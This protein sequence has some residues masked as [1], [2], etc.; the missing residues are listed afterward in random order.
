LFKRALAA[1]QQQDLVK[2]AIALQRVLEVDS[3]NALAWH[4]AGTIDLQR[5]NYEPASLKLARAVELDPARAEFHRTLAR[6][7]YAAGALADA[8]V[9]ARRAIDLDASS[10]DAWIVLG[11][12]LE[13]TEPDAALAAWEKAAALVPS[14]PEAQFRIGNMQRRRGNYVAA[15]SAYRAARAAGLNHPVLLNNLAL[16]LQEQEQFDEAEQCYQRA[17]EQQPTLLEANA[18]LGDLLYRR[19]R[20]AEALSSYGRAIALKPENSA[21]WLNLGLCQYRVAM[22]PAAEASLKRAIELDPHQPNNFVGM[23]A[24]LLAQQR[25]AEALPFIQRALELQPDLPDARSMQLYANQQTCNWEGLGLLF[26]QQRTGI[27][28]PDAPAVVPHNL[29]GL[30]YEPA[31]LLT[32]AR[33]W[34]AQRIRPKPIRRPPWPGLVEGRLRI[35]YLGSDFR[36]H[37]LANLLTEVI[38]RH[39]RSRFEVYGY[40]FGPDDKSAAR[41]RFIAAFDT[42]VDVR[43]ETFEQTAR[44]VRDDRI[45][46]LFDTGGYVLN[47]RSEIFALRPAPLQ[48]NCI[49]FPATLGADYY[50]YIL[51]DTFVTPPAQ[52]ENYAE[53]FMLLP[54][55]Y[56]PGDTRRPI[57]ETPTRAQCQLPATG[58]VF[59][60]FNACWKIHPML[61]DVWM[62]LLRKTPA[63]VLWLLDTNAASRDNLRRE[64]HQRGIA[65]ERLIFAPSLPLAEHLARHTVADLFLD[66]FP[67]NAHTTSNDAL[68]T[69]LPVLTCAGETFASRVSGSQLHA[70]GL[71]ELVTYS[72]ADYEALAL[73]LAN[74]PALLEGYRAR[75]RANR[76]RE[77][78]FDTVRYTRALEGLISAAA[79]ELRPAS[80]D[81]ER[82]PLA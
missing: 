31:E 71:P 68:F 64:A 25:E 23:A 65:P 66:T 75:L 48:I 13:A 6:A 51:A 61:F 20:F 58:F 30:P 69:G 1:Y 78:L 27:H 46:V 67:C 49:G 63:S 81:G 38:E 34:V 47:A 35:G 39:D 21:L 33:K 44:R 73:K 57:G 80:H 16:A 8:T 36:M 12:S 18:N 54:H 10:G 41:A 59:S 40:S 19:Q 60:C 77:P 79:D 42:F 7:R 32:A 52:R 9:S 62:R 45:A 82:A 15:V 74:E 26:E 22:L 28:D 14:Q 72:F 37:A 50:D 4:V 70:I 53:Q 3:G 55:C 43:P 56:L 17:I 29:L 76:S 5:G 11:L 24:V 2:A